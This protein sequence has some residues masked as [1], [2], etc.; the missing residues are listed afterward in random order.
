VRCIDV[1]PALDVAALVAGLAEELARDDDGGEIEVGL[2]RRGRVVVDVRETPLPRRDPGTVGIGPESVVLV[3]GGARGIT[4]ALSLALARET[5]CRLHLVGSRVPG[6][7]DPLLLACAD[8]DALRRHVQGRLA[9]VGGRPSSGAVEREVQRVLGDREVRTTLDGARRA[10]S[11]V[12]YHALDLRDTDAFRALLARIRAREGRI[13][14]VVHGAGIL[15]DGRLGE[16]TPASFRAVFDTKVRPAL[17]LAEALPADELRFL[18][19]FSSVAGRLGNAG[20]A[21]YAAANEVLNKLAGHL[22]RSRPQ[23]RVVSIGWGPWDGG[24]V[25]AAGRLRFAAAGVGLIPIEAGV[26]CCLAE[27]QAAPAD[28][29]EVLITPD[30]DALVRGLATAGSAPA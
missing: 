22:A 24:M 28:A 4:A 12:E 16:K 3:T 30:L 2:S 19:F 26:A 15:Q 11:E 7:E 21:D 6:P 1:D 20:Q 9:G 23:T 29:A 17:V 27:I 8:A 10:G 18:V 5:R 13:D 25:A 14:G